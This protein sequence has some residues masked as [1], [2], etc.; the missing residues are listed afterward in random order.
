MRTG[1]RSQRTRKQPA[2]VPLC[3]PQV[4]HDL[5]WDWTEQL[6]WGDGIQLPELWHG[7]DS[8]QV[9]IH[10]SLNKRRTILRIAV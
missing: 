10:L 2:A 5:P 3:P 6:R 1:K 8:N 4:A 9:H 7:S